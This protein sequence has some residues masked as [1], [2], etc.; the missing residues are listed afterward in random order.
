MVNNVFASAE[1]GLEGDRYQGRSGDRHV[2]LIQAEH[3]P[4][5]A[6]YAGLAQIAPEL[7]RRNIVVKGINL[8]ALRDKIITIGGVELAVTGLCHPCSRME[9]ILGAG[10]YNA[11]RGHGGV[12]ARV[13]TGGSILIGDSVSLRSGS[14]E[15]GL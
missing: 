5:I 12:T 1:R 10:G 2:T 8:L 3:L 7:L 14:D 11:M 6:S 13:L 15:S 4:A 9:E